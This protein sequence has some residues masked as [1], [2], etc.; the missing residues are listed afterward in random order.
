MVAVRQNSFA[1]SPCRRHGRT[2]RP[3]GR[4]G[5]AT[6][7][8]NVDFGHFCQV[9]AWVYESEM[10]PPPLQRRVYSYTV[11]V[12]PGALF[13]LVIHTRVH[14]RACFFVSVLVP[15]VISG[16][17][18]L[19]FARSSEPQQTQHDG[20]ERMTG[21]RRFLGK[22]ALSTRERERERERE[23]AFIREGNRAPV[24]KATHSRY[25]V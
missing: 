22:P 16:P 23:R 21:V 7:K 15:F 19:P 5:R 10:N 12:P 9:L 24:A 6:V 2:R 17:R 25:R 11:V 1:A 3:A 18:I 20:G 13:V 4:R 8:A 14:Q